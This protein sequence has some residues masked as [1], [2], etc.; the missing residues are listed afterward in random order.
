ML[1]P[2]RSAWDLIGSGDHPSEGGKVVKGAN[3]QDIHIQ[4]GS[5]DGRYSRVESD[6][7]NAISKQYG[8]DEAEFVLANRKG[9]SDL[10]DV[11]ISETTGNRQYGFGDSTSERQASD[12]EEM[13]QSTTMDIRAGTEQMFG[14]MDEQLGQQ[15]FQSEQQIELLGLDRLGLDLNERSLDLK[16]AGL[17]DQIQGIRGGMEQYGGGQTQSVQTGLITDEQGTIEQF[18]RQGTM[19]MGEVG[20][21]REELTIGRENLELARGKMD[22]QEDIIGSQMEGITTQSEIDKYNIAT[23][24][25]QQIANMMMQY[26]SATGEDIPDEFMSSWESYMETYG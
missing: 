4:G 9:Y 17:G 8:P 22:I 26:M 13:F 25:G 21:A 24:S 12:L 3:N 7:Y 1:E 6:I 18:E 10:R 5:K 23:S 2:Y 11:P 15:L 20:R 14:W 19:A 16:E